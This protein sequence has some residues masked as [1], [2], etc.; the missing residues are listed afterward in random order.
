[1]GVWGMSLLMVT[2]LGASL[3]LGKKLGSV[4]RV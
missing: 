2:L 1:M 3:L 4:F